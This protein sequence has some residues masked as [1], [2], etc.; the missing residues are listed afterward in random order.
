MPTSL[1]QRLN[2]LAAS[3]ASTVLGAIRGAS[4]EDLLAESSKNGRRTGQRAAGGDGAAMRA[5]RRRPG[6][7]PRRSADDIAKVVERILGLLQQNP[8]GL[9]AEQ[10]R[11]ALG[12]QAKELPRPLKEALDTGRVA[13]SGQKRATT[14]TLKSGAAAAKPRRS[15]SAGRRGGRS[16]AARKGRGASKRASKRGHPAEKKAAGGGAE[17]SQ[18]GN[19]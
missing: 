14:Y 17:A 5:P 18:G 13:K 6:R 12:L 4:L 3:F 19:G 15:S 16:G 8:K 11:D 7:L 2:E 9:R 10:I 1:R